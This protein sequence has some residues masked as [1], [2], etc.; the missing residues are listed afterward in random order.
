M[1]VRHQRGIA[2]P[3]AAGFAIA[4]AAAGALVAGSDSP[5]PVAAPAM[6]SDVSVPLAIKREKVREAGRGVNVGAEAAA[7]GR[8]LP[9]SGQGRVVIPSPEAEAG[10]EAGDAQAERESGE[11]EGESETLTGPAAQQVDQRA[12]PRTYVESKRAVASRKAFRALPNSLSRS[13]F[14]KSATPRQLAQGAPIAAAWEVLGPVTPTVPGPVTI[15]GRET[16][17]SGRVTALALDPNCSTFPDPCRLWVAAAGGGI[18]R[19]TNALAPKPTWEPVDNGLPT[20]AFGSIYVDPTDPTGDTLYAGSGEPN[21]SGDSEAGLGLFKSTDGG[22]SWSLVPG[23]AA[24]ARDRSISS[25]SVDPQDPDTIWIGTALARHGLSAVAGGRLTPPNAPALGVYRSTDGGKFF[26]LQLNRPGS[27]ANPADGEDWFQGGVTKLV[28]DPNDPKQLYA[29]VNGYGIFRVHN[30]NDGVCKCDDGQWHQ[31]YQSLYGD[32]TFLGVDP[33]PYGTRIEFDLVDNGGQTR[34]YVGDGSD[35]YV[36]A[37]VT[38]GDGVE[39]YSDSALLAAQRAMVDPGGIQ[40]PWS[41]RSNPDINESL[42]GYSSF[43]FCQNGQ[44]LYDMFVVA[45]P[46]DPDVVWLGGAMAYDELADWGSPMPRSNGRAVVRSTDAGVSFTDMTA[47]SQDPPLGQ[48][49]DQHALVLNPKKP[50]QAFIGSDGGVVRTNGTFVD[51]NPGDATCGSR[52]FTGPDAAADLEFC[53]R[54][55]RSIPEQIDSLNDGLNT[56]QFQSVNFNPT[57][58][59]DDLLGGTQDNGSWIWRGGNDWFESVGG[60]GGNSG[61]SA[62]GSSRMH[63]YYGPTPDVSFDDGAVDSWAIVYGPM[64]EAYGQGE[65]FSFY[66]PLLADPV[67]AGT[68]FLGGQYVWRTQNSGGDKDYLKANCLESSWNGADCGDFE[69]IGPEVSADDANFIAAL[70]RGESDA[71]TLWI[72]LRRGGLFVSSNADAA[73]GAVTYTQLTSPKIPNRFVSGIAVDPKDANHAWISYSGYSAYTPTTPGHIFEARFDPATKTATLTDRSYDIGD[74]PV[75]GISLDSLTGD[76]YAATDFGVARLASGATSWMDSA[77]AMPQVA[78]YWVTTSGPSRVLYAATHGRGIYRLALNPVARIAG[79]AVGAVGTPLTF[80]NEGSGGYQST[81]YS[82]TL[83]SGATA[84]GSQAKFTPTKTGKQ[85]VTLTVTDSLGH[86]AVATHEVSVSPNPQA[87]KSP[88]KPTVKAGVSSATVTVKP[89]S[90]GPK[91]T[92]LKVSASPGNATCTAT[93]PATSCVVKGL[94]PGKSYTYRAVAQNAAG[95]SDP[96]PASPAVRQLIQQVPTKALNLPAKLKNRGTTRL[97]RIP[98][99]TNAGQVATVKVTGVPVGA[100]RT[101]ALRAGQADQFRVIR[102][103]GWVSVYLPGTTAMRVTVTVTAPAKSG[104]TSYAS[105][106]RYTT[107][108]A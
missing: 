63:T 27:S 43:N 84:T 23:S 92:S 65:G 60:D 2:L 46:S 24:V 70:A 98:V 35:S 73:P 16:T 81:T 78:S 99:R 106:K 22:D 6:R 101:Q 42:D 51:G 79:P 49:P 108:R 62:D 8:V 72:G 53:R 76:L 55:L 18:W 14:R 1:S 3:V 30:P 10:A 61:I 32:G 33:D 91:A 102:R 100:T 26:S 21:G 86:T 13:D 12:Y 85:T 5:E 29:S 75:T 90:S 74:Q 68:Y 107:S 69:R 45:D 25:I 50:G 7:E 96:G 95:V 54:V 15:T 94:T 57:K 59:Y 83:P 105:V 52:T 80:T 47:D 58:P 56:L 67:V 17:D 71:S 9:P 88:G 64:E 34:L 87:P 104:Y 11:P 93:L 19:T 97:V 77:A 20:N 41:L 31:V 82:W 103:A 44:C 28:R 66:A 4:I 39:G 37:Y 48:H 36:S 89:A 38:V 40:A